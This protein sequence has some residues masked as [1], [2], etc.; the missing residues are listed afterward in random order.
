[1]KN[2]LKILLGFFVTLV[3]IPLSIVISYTIISKLTNIF[4]AGYESAILNVAFGILGLLTLLGFVVILEKIIEKAIEKKMRFMIICTVV[5]IIFF[6]IGMLTLNFN[7]FNLQKDM[8]NVDM[9]LLSESGVLSVSLMSLS[10]VFVVL[11]FIYLIVFVM[12]IIVHKLGEIRKN[13]KE[14]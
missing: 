7:F 13:R 14:I 5:P 12:Y 11:A 2:V 4:N 8:S 9:G 6:C 3:Y 1:M 10:S